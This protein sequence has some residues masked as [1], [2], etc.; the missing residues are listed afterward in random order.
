MRRLLL[1]LVASFVFAC[2]QPGS[3]TGDDDDDT[4][5]TS[6]SP[7]PSETQTPTPTPGP[8]SPSLAT[9]QT[10]VQPHLVNSNCTNG[11]SCHISDQPRIFIPPADAGEEQ[12]NYERLICC[13]RMYTYDN[14]GGRLF[15]L[16]CNGPGD[17]KATPSHPDVNAGTMHNGSAQSNQFCTDLANWQVEG[18][19]GTP[20]LC[21]MAQDPLC[22]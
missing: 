10:T 2:G 12:L 17:A 5:T 3:T 9:Y 13:P 18:A 8:G 14:P 11:G 20:Q 21:F 16:F 7:S 22:N 6:P 15:D 4:S 1:L 19:G